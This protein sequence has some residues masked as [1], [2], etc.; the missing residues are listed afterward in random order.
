MHL[1]DRSEVFKLLAWFMM[2]EKM[3]SVSI[4]TYRNKHFYGGYSK[5]TISTFF[6]VKIDGLRK[7]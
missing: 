5:L 4:K 7:V 1:V 6:S 2:E 3:L